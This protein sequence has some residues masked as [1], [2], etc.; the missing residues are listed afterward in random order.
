[1]Y[2]YSCAVYTLNQDYWPQLF[3]IQTA[4]KFPWWTFIRWSEKLF[5]MIV[6]IIIGSRSKM[7]IKKPSC[8]NVCMGSETFSHHSLAA[9]SSENFVP[10]H[11]M[12]HKCICQHPKDWLQWSLSSFLSCSLQSC[13]KS[14]TWCCLKVETNSFHPVWTTASWEQETLRQCRWS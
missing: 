1:M 13:L 5:E 12:P 3:V 10:E 14:D 6:C 11:W 7:N 2:E 9:M 8:A 4:S